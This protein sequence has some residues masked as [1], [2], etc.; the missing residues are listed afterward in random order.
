[1][2]PELNSQ[3]ARARTRELMAPRRHTPSPLLVALKALRTRQ[4]R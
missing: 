3:L 4:S 2:N 1:M